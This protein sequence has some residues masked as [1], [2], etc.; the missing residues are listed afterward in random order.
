MRWRVIVLKKLVIARPETRSFSSHGIMQSLQNFNVIFFVDRPTSWSKF[1]VHKTLTIE[2][3]NK[4]WLD[5]APT[6]TCFLTAC[7]TPLSVLC[8]YFR[9]QK[10]SVSFQSSPYNSCR[11]W[12]KTSCKLVDLFFLSFLTVNKCDKW[13]Q[14]VGYKHTLSATQGVRPVSTIFREFVR[15]YWLCSYPA[16]ANRALWREDINAGQIL[17]GHASYVR[18]REKLTRIRPKIEAAIPDVP[19]AP[20]DKITINI[21]RPLPVTQAGNE[22]ILSI[23]DVLTKYIILITLKETSSES[24]IAHLLDHYIYVSS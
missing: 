1:V 9:P 4:H 11:D 8:P 12:S 20:N 21:F 7:T 6:L 10:P 17:F 3:N 16:K 13:K 14:H 15:D 24:I 2:K 5:M 19:V 18:E 22:Y 23:Q